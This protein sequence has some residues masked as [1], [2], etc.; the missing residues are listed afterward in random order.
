MRSLQSGQHLWERTLLIVRPPVL[1]LLLQ[2]GEQPPKLT[3]QTTS[4]WH[5]Q[6]YP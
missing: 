2:Q 5:M 4:L 3:A 1:I 6:I